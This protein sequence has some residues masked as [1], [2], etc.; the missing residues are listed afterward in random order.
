MLNRIAA[1]VV[2]LLLAGCVIGQSRAPEAA[3]GSAAAVEQTEKAC[4]AAMQTGDYSVVENF[5]ADDFILTT[6]YGATANKALYLDRLR[7]GR[8]RPTSVV[9]DDVRVRVYGDAAIITGRS[10]GQLM[11]NGIELAVVE[12]YTHVYAK[13]GD[14]WRIVAM[15]MSVGT[16]PG[17]RRGRRN[18]RSDG[19]GNET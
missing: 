13:Q 19:N 7:S 6:P 5:I 1:P 11:I 18:L 17:S 2:C 10:T 12:R 15:Q 8:P 14:Q 16:V 9:H 3:A 4:L